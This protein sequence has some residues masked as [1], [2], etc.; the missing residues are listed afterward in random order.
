ME[1]LEKKKKRGERNIINHFLECKNCTGKKNVKNEWCKNISLMIKLYIFKIYVVRK[2]KKIV[3]WRG[4]KDKPMNLC[5]Q[6]P[7]MQKLIN[8]PRM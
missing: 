4:V 5:I 2:W 6:K 3:E 7:K 1:K 8:T